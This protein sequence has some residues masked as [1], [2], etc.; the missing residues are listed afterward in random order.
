MWKVRK[1]V[2]GK[3]WMVTGI[4]VVST[5]TLILILAAM[6]IAVDGL[7]YRNYLENVPLYK[8]A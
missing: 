7:R 4:I 3:R 1:G 8:P 5:V 6:L 2:G